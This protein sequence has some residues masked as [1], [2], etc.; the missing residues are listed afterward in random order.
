LVPSKATA[1]MNLYGSAP[2]MWIPNGEKIFISLPGV[3]YEM[4]ALLQNEVIPRLRDAY[5]LPVIYHRTLM[6]YGLGESMIAARIEAFEDSLPNF[7]KLAY[8][9]NLG[10]VRLRLTGKGEDKEQV[11][12]GVEAEIKKLIPLIEDIFHGFEDEHSVEEQIG[13][14]LMERQQ[15]MA[16]AESCTGGQIA[17]MITSH[18]G[19]S[20]YFKGSVVSYSTDA[21]EDILGVDPALIKKHSVVSI[22]VAKAMAEQVKAIFKADY[23]ISTTGNAGPSKGDSEAEVGTVCIGIAT[24]NGVYAKEFHMGNHRIKVINKAVNKALELMLAEISKK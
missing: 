18:A 19:A 16:T 7:I 14:K 5:H 21:K 12:A 1:L 13:Q 9:P 10:R 20:K 17:Q 24:P 2:G 8:L 22:E 3:P 11:E 4:K 15:S 6:T 23:A